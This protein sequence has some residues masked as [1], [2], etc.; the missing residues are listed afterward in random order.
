MYILIESY[1]GEIN[2][3]LCA[4]IESALY[5]KKEYIDYLDNNGI[6]YT[7]EIDENNYLSGEIND[8]I[9]TIEIR[10]VKVFDIN[11]L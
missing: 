1:D 4:N 2:V 10:P 11:I 8:M 6:Q 3:D 5:K 7:I 9:Y